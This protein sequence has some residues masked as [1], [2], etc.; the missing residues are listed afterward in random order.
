MKSKELQKF[1]GSMLLFGLLLS[2]MTLSIWAKPEDGGPNEQLFVAKTACLNNMDACGSNWETDM[3][4]NQ[5]K[6]ATDTEIVPSNEGNPPTASARAP[7]FTRRITKTFLDGTLP[8]THTITLQF[9]CEYD[10]SITHGNGG[11][12]KYGVEI[13]GKSM[14]GPG[15]PNY[16]SST[17]SYLHVARLTLRQTSIPDTVWIATEST[18]SVNGGVAPGNIRANLGMNPGAIGSAPLGGY[19]RSDFNR[20]RVTYENYRNH[21]VQSIKTEL[22]DRSMLTQNKDKFC[23]ESHF[24]DYGNSPQPAKPLYAE[25]EVTIINGSNLDTWTYTYPYTGVAIAIL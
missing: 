20:T 10:A 1:V 12:V 13:V 19:S 4:T 23:V 6:A 8:Q 25:W 16:H 17:E 11:Y 9:S 14:S 2:L 24:M 3:L 21:Y 5:V 7:G 15:A 18:R 22:P